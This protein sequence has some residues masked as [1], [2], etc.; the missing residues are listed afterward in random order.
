MPLRP[1]FLEPDEKVLPAFTVFFHALG[2]TQG[3]SITFMIH[4][5]GYE[6]RNVLNLTAPASL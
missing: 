2:G 4:A 5:N 1:L 3:L 6:N